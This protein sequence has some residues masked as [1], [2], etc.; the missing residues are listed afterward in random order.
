MGDKNNNIFT[1]EAKEIIKKRDWLDKDIEK[2]L[3]DYDEVFSLV[4]EVADDLAY[5]AMRET[6]TFGDVDKVSAYIIKKIADRDTPNHECIASREF[7]KEAYKNRI[8][9]HSIR[10]II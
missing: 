4:R 10:S 6:K 3:K 9:K 5:R 1:E 8:D 2:S 7:F